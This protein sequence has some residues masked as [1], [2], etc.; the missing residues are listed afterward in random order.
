[1]RLL[2]RDLVEVATPAP[3]QSTDDSEVRSV[4]AG[5]GSPATQR[6]VLVLFF[7]TNN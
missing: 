5:A 2:I 4:V 7:V 6:I 1:M 3:G